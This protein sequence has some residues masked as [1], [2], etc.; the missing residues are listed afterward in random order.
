MLRG[1]Y[2]RI[3]AGA[4]V[5]EKADLAIS[6]GQGNYTSLS[7]SN[8]DISL[9]LKVKC[10][11]I[12]EKAGS[13]VGES[14][15]IQGRHEHP[16]SI[17]AGLVVAARSDWVKHLILDGHADSECLPGEGAGQRTS[18]ANTPE[19]FNPAGA[20]G[21]VLGS[22]DKP[23]LELAL[24]GRDI[25]QVPGDKNRGGIIEVSF[26]VRNEYSWPRLA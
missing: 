1:L 16:G 10:A 2:S 13:Q 26:L 18:S 24:I 11:V 5:N 17:L 14:V 8:R 4:F 19:L 15:L 25:A 3:A 7:D 20:L 6:N 22:R 12:A 23:D 9:L 21:L